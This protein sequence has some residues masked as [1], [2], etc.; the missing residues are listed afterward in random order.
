MLPR[1][2]PG[3][4][5]GFT[6]SQSMPRGAC[7]WCSFAV[8]AM[9]FRIYPERMGMS[10]LFS[11]AFWFSFFTAVCKATS[12]NHFA[13]LHFFFLGVIL[14]PASWT[15]SRTS[16]Q[17]SSGTLSDLIP[18]IYFHFHSTIIRDL[19]L[20]HNWIVYWLSLLSLSLNF[21]ISSSWSDPQS[22]PGLVFAYCITMQEMRVQSLGQE[23]TLRRKC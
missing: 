22:A 14:I 16:V 2:H 17:R 11:F 19:H 20:G 12:D 15:M 9:K 10:F 4:R 3:L 21:A 5:A 23:D 7:M 18:W 8:T 13:F 6:G 1:K